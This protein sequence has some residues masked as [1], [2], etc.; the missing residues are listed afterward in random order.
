M[1]AP[2]TVIARHSLHMELFIIL[3]SCPVA[4]EIS[5]YDIQFVPV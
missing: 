3:A 1:A 2:V 4:R 5:R